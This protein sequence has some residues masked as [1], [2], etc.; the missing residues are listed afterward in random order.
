MIEE[1]NIKKN[2][3]KVLAWPAYA[4]K[5][6]NPYNYLLYHGIEKMGHEI[7]EFEFSIKNVLK[8]FFLRSFDILHIHWPNY[9][10]SVKGAIQAKRRLYTFFAFVQGIRMFNKKVV[11]TVHNLESHECDY[12]VLE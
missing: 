5:R 1:F 8:F 6:E 7:F 10:L 9:I 3:L 12:T 2:K 11:W 4:N